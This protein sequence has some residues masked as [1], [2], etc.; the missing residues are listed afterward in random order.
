MTSRL[1]HPI[2]IPLLVLLT[3]HPGNGQARLSEDSLFVPSLGRTKK[4]RVLQPDHRDL[5]GRLPCL[6]LLHGFGGNYRNWTEFTTLQKDLG[7]TRLIVI[8][9]DGENA[10]Y[11]NS[12]A[13]SS[14][15]FEDYLVGDLL[16][17]VATRYAVDTTRIGIA[18]LSMGGFGALTLG[19]RH[20]ET[21]RFI[22][23]MSASLD[24]PYGITTLEEHGRGGL[25]EDLEK[26][27]GTDS[28]RWAS[29]D[30][31]RLLAR[32]DS[33]EIPYLYLVNGIQDEFAQRI[34]YYREFAST[35]S[36]RHLPYEY[37]ETPGHHDWSYWE[38][39]IP[40]VVRRFMEI[41]H[42]SGTTTH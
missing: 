1:L 37:H 20:P 8:M 21:F 19:L 35:L 13:D 39:E 27:F 31:F 38:R 15:R 28:S 25:R 22:G 7:T 14:D 33:A 10:W 26:A 32:S 2:L 40:G 5:S 11:T 41:V 42:P 3:I 4:F 34:D 23:A 12:V 30:A 17:T 24:I 16:H 29:H 18:G 9:P 6:L 36:Y